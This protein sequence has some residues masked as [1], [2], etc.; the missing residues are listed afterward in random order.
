MPSGGPDTV[1]KVLQTYVPSFKKL[2]AT[3]DLSK[4]YT[5]DFAEKAS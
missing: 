1:L 4:T 2:N 5:N 3:I